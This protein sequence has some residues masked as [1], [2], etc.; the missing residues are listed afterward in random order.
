MGCCHL[1]D[2]FWMLMVKVKDITL[3]FPF[4]HWWNITGAKGKGY[5]AQ[6]WQ[7]RVWTGGSHQLCEP[8]DSLSI[9][10]PL[11]STGVQNHPHREIIN[12]GLLSTWSGLNC[13]LYFWTY[14][15]LPLQVDCDLSRA[16]EM[17]SIP[18]NPSHT[19]WIITCVWTHSLLWVALCS[20]P[21]PKPMLSPKKSDLVWK[22]GHQRRT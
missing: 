11:C 7:M 8:L 21:M 3:D 1:W 17:F 9:S 10:F 4:P 20:S 16:G 6:V 12:E 15:N 19:C 5:W 18:L 2:F 14:S 13:F 22:Q